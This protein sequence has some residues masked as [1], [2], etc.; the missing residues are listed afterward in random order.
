MELLLFRKGVFL[1]G[2]PELLARYTRL[3]SIGRIAEISYFKFYRLATG[4]QNLTACHKQAYAVCIVA[5]SVG[6]PDG[7]NVK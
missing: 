7:F 3:A 5:C 1:Q 4:F 2:Y 6:W